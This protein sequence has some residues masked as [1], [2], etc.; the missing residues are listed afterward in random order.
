MFHCSSPKKTAKE[1]ETH[2]NKTACV[3]YEIINLSLIVLYKQV[4]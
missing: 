3:A 2:T 4:L 1:Y